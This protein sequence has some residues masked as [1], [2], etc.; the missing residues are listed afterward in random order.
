MKQ[1]AAHRA[2]YGPQRG[3]D[4][5]VAQADLKQV[6]LAWLVGAHPRADRLVIEHRLFGTSSLGDLAGRLGVSREWIR[7]IET[8]VLRNLMRWCFANGQPALGRRIR[9]C[10]GVA[11]PARRRVR[12]RSV[13]S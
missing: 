13:T 10:V 2:L 12:R 6:A 9:R 3:V 1:P 4:L 5:T 8:R 11:A 7:Q